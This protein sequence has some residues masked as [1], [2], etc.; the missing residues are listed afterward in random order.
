LRAFAAVG[1][2]FGRLLARQ[3]QP[4]GT[5]VAAA[6]GD[7]AVASVWARGGNVMTEPVIELE[8]RDRRRAVH[9]RLTVAGTSPLAAA[10]LAV[11][12]DDDEGPADVLARIHRPTGPGPG[13]AQ[14]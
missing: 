2:F 7:T 14:R 6:K 1:A 3:P 8:L 5:L 11:V 12:P 4:E 13:G 10:L 9:T